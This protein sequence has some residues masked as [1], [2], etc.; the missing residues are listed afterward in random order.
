[1]I[2]RPTGS[3]T[4]TCRCEGVW[5][6][7]RLCHRPF[8]KRGPKRGHN[9]FSGRPHSKLSSPPLTSAPLSA[10][11]SL[12][13][14]APQL[15][16][17]RVS[18]SVFS[19]TGGETGV[20]RTNRQCLRYR[21]GLW[22]CLGCPFYWIPPLSL[23]TRCPCCLWMGCTRTCL[24]WSVT[25]TGMRQRLSRPTQLLLPGLSDSPSWAPPSTSGRQCQGTVWETFQV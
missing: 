19:T 7:E 10:S 22:S 12:A 5:G 13:G 6:V 8:S 9:S 1:M 2:L 24:P 11:H 23:V 21:A 20:Q 25:C 15:W 14:F 16:S 3:L 17:L 18:I 4:E